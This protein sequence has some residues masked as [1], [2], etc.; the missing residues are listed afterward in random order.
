MLLTCPVE[1]KTGVF[2]FLLNRFATLKKIIDRYLPLN[3]NFLYQIFEG[4]ID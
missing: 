1:I 3:P 2:Q 4:K